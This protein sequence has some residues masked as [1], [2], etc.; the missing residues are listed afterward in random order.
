MTCFWTT[1]YKVHVSGQRCTGFMFLYL[2]E[3]FRNSLCSYFYENCSRVGD[4]FTGSLTTVNP[5]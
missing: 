1:L 4:M 3:L 2:H 5:F